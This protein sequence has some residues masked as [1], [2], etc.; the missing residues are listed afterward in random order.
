MKL[1]ANICTFTFH[2][3]LQ[4]AA[5]NVFRSMGQQSSRKALSL[6][7]KK[8]GNRIFKVMKKYD[9]FAV[10]L[11]EANEWAKLCPQP[12][13]CHLEFRVLINADVPKEY[14][15]YVWKYAKNV[16]IEVRKLRRVEDPISAS[17]SGQAREV[18]AGIAGEV[19]GVP[20]LMSV[21][22]FYYVYC[23][24]TGL[25]SIHFHTCLALE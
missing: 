25:Y 5:K 19:I 9:D 22:Q 20:K 3:E 2:G 21:H 10:H 8:K 23:L 11:I 24:L 18:H 15:P 13:A 6:D 4:L 17:I 7:E 16:Q 12:R 14:L 1:L